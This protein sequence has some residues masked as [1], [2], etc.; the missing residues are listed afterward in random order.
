MGLLDGVEVGPV[1]Q[2]HVRDGRSRS[3]ER[4]VH[5]CGAGPGAQG[6]VS[7]VGAGVVVLH[8]LLPGP[9]LGGAPHTPRVSLAGSLTGFEGDGFALGE[10]VEPSEGPPEPH[11]ARTKTPASAATCF[12]T[13]GDST[14][15]A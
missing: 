8:G 14:E 6:D 1:D 11:A 7:E 3:G 2:E 4:G 13:R 9:D 10:L 5:G 15:M 12:H